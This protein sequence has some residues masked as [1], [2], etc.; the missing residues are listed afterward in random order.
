MMRIVRLFSLCIAFV[1]VALAGAAPARS[2]NMDGKGH[3]PF[4]KIMA[5]TEQT[6]ANFF[7]GVHIHIIDPARYVNVGPTA[8]VPIVDMTG[9]RER[10]RKRSGIALSFLTARRILQEIPAVLAQGEVAT[11]LYPLADS[12]T[13]C[14]ITGGDPHMTLENALARMTR[15]ERPAVPQWV[16]F[17]VTA[18]FRLLLYHEIAH[19]SEDLGRYRSRDWTAYNTYM[20]ENLGDAF[21]VLLHLRDTGDDMLPHF[22]ALLRRTMLLTTND[23]EHMTVP[24]IEAA[25]LWG[26]T[27]LH[28]GRLQAMSRKALFHQAQRLVATYA[29]TP[30]AFS[31]FEANMRMAPAHAFF[32]SHLPPQRPPIPAP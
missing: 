22:F 13:L 25:R 31:R 5:T 29:L 28:G 24:T 20:A 27:R 11:G 1:A 16:P 7:E 32:A 4:A 3:T 8:A 10:L 26:A 21:A 23:I 12:R 6:F 19:C 14:L 2:Q 30:H 17:D 9:F 15:L 18:L